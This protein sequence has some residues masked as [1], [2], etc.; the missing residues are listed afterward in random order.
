MQ[1]PGHPDGDFQ[2]TF[3]LPQLGMNLAH[4]GDAVIVTY[5]QGEASVLGV[6]LGDQ[7]SIFVFMTSCIN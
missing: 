2:L 4:V 5:T 1:I 3:Q 6:K 7:V